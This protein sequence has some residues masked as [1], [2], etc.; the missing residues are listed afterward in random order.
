MSYIIQKR[1]NQLS[2]KEK[3]QLI[4]LIKRYYPFCSQGFIDNR[5]S[6]SCKS[7][8]VLL[9]NKDMVL[10]ASYYTVDKF[11]TPFFNKK[12][13]VVEFGQAFKKAGYKGNIIWRMGHWYAQ[14]NI[15]YIYPIKRTVGFSMIGSPKV[16]ENFTKSFKNHY[17]NLQSNKLGKDT[18][19]VSF[20]ENIYKK[21]GLKLNSDLNHCFVKMDFKPIDITNDW[22]RYYKSNNELIN[23]FFI[24]NEIIKFEGNKI[25]DNNLALI[26]CG[27][28]NPLGLSCH[29]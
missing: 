2:D 20:L 22:E 29:Y 15:G 21:K 23:T 27:Y 26:V 1:S 5:I 16:F 10:G 14:R 6:E 18:S 8:I 4:I 28:R 3:N 12:T 17:P 13:P 9:K 11:K 24:E 19:I 25:Y 7:D